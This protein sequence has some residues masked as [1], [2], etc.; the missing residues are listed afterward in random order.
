MELYIYSFYLNYIHICFDILEE[1]FRKLFSKKFLTISLFM[2]YAFR[3]HQYFFSSLFCG[4]RGMPCINEELK[5]L[6]QGLNSHPLQWK[7][8]VLTNGPSGESHALIHTSDVCWFWSPSLL[9]PPTFN[10]VGIL[11]CRPTTSTRERQKPRISFLLDHLSTYPNLNKSHQS[12]SSLLLP[13]WYMVA[14]EKSP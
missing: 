6:H 8:G 2:K 5:S 4:E 3:L 7:H 10:S 12:F 9:P 1:K 14:R 13:S 11:K